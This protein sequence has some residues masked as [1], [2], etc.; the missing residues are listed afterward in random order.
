[1]A[2]RPAL[3]ILMMSISDTE[4]EDERLR[5]DYLELNDCMA[6]LRKKINT[7]E[8]Q[9]RYNY[10][11]II[12]VPVSM[13]DNCVKVVEEI[14]AVL[15]IALTVVK[16]E[17]LPYDELTKSNRIVAE[18]LTY[19]QKLN[20]MTKSKRD[21]LT[22]NCV[23]G[24]AIGTRI[25]IHDFLTVYNRILYFHAKNF[26]REKGFKYIWYADCQIFMRRY[27]RS[28]IFLIEKESDFCSLN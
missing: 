1:M 21:Q 20:L 8:Q 26:A 7:L 18:L 25:H 16:A 27:D 12:G 3:Q 5:S 28:Q 9:N 24:N 10:V 19:G 15:E 2:H 14:G 22:F 23:V 11:E 6:L 13:G 17:R 4:S